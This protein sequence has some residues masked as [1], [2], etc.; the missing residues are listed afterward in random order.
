MPLAPTEQE[1]WEKSQSPSIFHTDLSDYEERNRL[2]E[3]RILTEINHEKLPSFA[4]SLKKQKYMDLRPFY[5]RRSRWDTIMQSRLIESFLINIP[6]PP[7]HLFEINYN[8]YEVIDGQ[9]R[10]TTIK[11]FYENLLTLTNLDIWDN[12]N[13]YTY[14]ELP[15]DIKAKID[16]RSISSIV[17]ITESTS[18]DEEGLFLKQKTFERLNTGGVGLTSQEIR[19]CLYSGKF[20]DLL[21]ELSRHPT[22]A[23]AWGIPTDD[24]S[25]ELE[26]NDLYKKMEDVELVLRFFAL[27]NV[28]NFSRG[29]KDFLD[30]YMRK[31]L[32]FSQEDVY[33]LKQIFQETINLASLV[34]GDHLFKPFDPQSEN[35][36]HK[37]YKAYYDAVMVGFSEHLEDSEKLLD[38]KSRIREETTKLFQGENAYLFTGGGKTKKDVQDRIRIFSNMLS[39]VIGE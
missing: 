23:K 24:N 21:L 6:V 38:K 16:R 33:F 27:R 11:N 39:Q 12:L 2:R 7:I 20:N 10:I 9:Q 15:P 37:S 4:E 32:H 36:T 35:W 31:S 5:Q 26:K 8:R 13:G 19:N 3:K 25:S 29:M 28:D 34:Y 30:L 18:N 22:F 14:A 1:M 17:I